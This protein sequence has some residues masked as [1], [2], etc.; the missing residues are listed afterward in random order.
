MTPPDNQTAR[1]IVSFEQ[2][3]HGDW[4]ARLNCGHTQHVRHQPPWMNR[5]W[6]ATEDGRAARVGNKLRCAKCTSESS[7]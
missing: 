4:L 3:D 2:D 6:V 5:E 7:S 1:T